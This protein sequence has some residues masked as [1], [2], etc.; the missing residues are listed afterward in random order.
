MTELS[1]PDAIRL[2]AM[3]RQQATGTY[4][5][6][7]T[8]G[9]CA[10]GAALDAIGGLAARNSKSNCPG[11]LLRRRWPALQQPARNPVTGLR[12]SDL[13]SVI[14]TLNDA[15]CWT[16]EQIADWLDTLEP[17]AEAKADEAESLAR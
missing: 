8:G 17:V 10:L 15:N 6:V 12:H 7:L 4:Y 2:G 16:R 9:T 14:Y 5:S 1:L 3:N 13:F 11:M